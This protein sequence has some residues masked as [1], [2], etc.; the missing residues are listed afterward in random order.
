M[1]KMVADITVLFCITVLQLRF[2]NITGEVSHTS[3]SLSLNLFYIMGVKE[4]P[5]NITDEASNHRLLMAILQAVYVWVNDDR[6][7]L[8]APDLH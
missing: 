7:Y 2:C 4:N 1:I 3:F 5:R 8:L 6:S